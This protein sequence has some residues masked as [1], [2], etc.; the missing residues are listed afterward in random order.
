[1]MTRD[2]NIAWEQTRGTGVWSSLKAFAERCGLVNAGV[3]KFGPVLPWTYQSGRHTSA[4]DHVLVSRKL[5]KDGCMLQM[6]V[7]Q[8]G[9]VND[10]DHKVVVVELDLTPYLRVTDRGMRTPRPKR[11]NV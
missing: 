4:I 5:I 8:E 3:H 1:M 6:G 2:F 9:T 11:K 7:W 10:S